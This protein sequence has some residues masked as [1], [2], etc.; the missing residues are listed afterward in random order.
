ARRLVRAGAG[1]EE[2]VALLLPRSPDQVVSVLAVLKAG[3]AFVP[4]DPSY[5]A[6]RT[7]YV[8]ADCGARLLLTHREQARQLREAGRLPERSALSVLLLDE[9]PDTPED[10]PAP[11]AGLPPLP[12]VPLTA[13][14]YVIYTSGSTGCPKGV[15]VTHAGLSS[16]AAT[17]ASRL[18]AGPGSRVLQFASPGFDASWWELSMALLTGAAL[19]VDPPEP[20]AATTDWGSRLGPVVAATGVTHATLPPALVAALDPA[21]LP[22]VL[23]VAG[24]ACPP[25]TVQRYA[26]GR[27][28]VNAYG[29]T[30]TSV[31]ATMSAPLTPAPGTPP[32]GTPVT[33]A[34]T[35]VLDAWLR[36]VPVGVP[37]EL[38]V[39]GSGLARGYL[40]RPGLTSGAFVA[41]PFGGGGRLYRTG[42]VVRRRADGALEYLA[43]R[44]DQLKVRGFRVEP[45]EIENVLARHA[46]VA[47]VV[48]DARPA[49][50]A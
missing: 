27:T 33:A 3:A 5:P 8:L 37:G 31:C 24:E 9:A 46:S 25:E 28:L 45:R 35:Y 42:D 18:G 16:L 7:G 47:Q 38:Y 20:G 10:T 39:A 1:P 32:I 30:E 50:T 11:A 22:P 48:V 29:P 43:R 36:P 40:D 49:G 2:R 26:P 6:D 15:T 17:Q 4:V 41:D 34:A 19:V 44:D 13:G 12:E 14:A 21:A 23:V